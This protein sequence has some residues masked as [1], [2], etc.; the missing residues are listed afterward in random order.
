[1]ENDIFDNFINTGN[2]KPQQN[3]QNE[4]KVEFI[5]EETGQVETASVNQNLYN[6]TKRL[7]KI[8]LI[9]LLRKIIN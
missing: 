5:D 2:N 4:E 6:N 3:K 8:T 7:L 9:N 1:M